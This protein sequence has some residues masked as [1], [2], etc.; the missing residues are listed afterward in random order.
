M[1]YQ[2][3]YRQHENSSVEMKN[4]LEIFTN[5]AMLRILCNVKFT[6]NESKRINH[7]GIQQ[8]WDENSSRRKSE[9]TVNLKSGCFD[10]IDSAVITL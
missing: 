2:K 3:Y 5:A 7:F 4:L 8:I 6:K 10:K 1:T 9:V